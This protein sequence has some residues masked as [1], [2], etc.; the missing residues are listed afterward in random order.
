MTDEK[1]GEVKQSYWDESLR[2]SFAK[3]PWYSRAWKM[4]KNWLKK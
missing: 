1:I 2:P 3:K 4:T